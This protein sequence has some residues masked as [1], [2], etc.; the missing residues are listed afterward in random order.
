MTLTDATFIAGQHR[1][2]SGDSITTQGEVRLLTGAEVTLQARQLRFQPGFRVAAG[3]KL[4][5]SVGAAN[6]AAATG[7]PARVG[8]ELRPDAASLQASLPAS[9]AAPVT[10]PLTALARGQS[11]PPA[12]RLITRDEITTGTLGALLT[13]FGIDPGAIAQAL[14]AEDESWLLFE[15]TQDLL[16]ADRNGVSD[17][18]RLDLITEDLLLV[19]R[20]PLGAAAN[21]PSRYPA[22]DARGDLILFQSDGSDLVGDDDN[23]VTDIFLYELGLGTTRRLTTQASQASAH[24]TLA[25]SGEALVYDQG[26]EGDGR[27]VLADSPWENSPGAES[28]SLA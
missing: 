25:A 17:I 24:P 16:Q 23:G 13:A 20:T 19:S 26:G 10:T 2:A 9:L 1:L 6:C 11:I 15:T 4:K 7:A 5:V 21:G 18:Y 27:Q 28:L 12:P 8:D 3:A 22:S 14:L